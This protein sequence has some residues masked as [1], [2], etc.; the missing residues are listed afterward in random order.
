M[1]DVD[2]IGFYLSNGAATTGACASCATKTM[3]V[4]NNRP[5]IQNICI[6]LCYVFRAAIHF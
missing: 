1:V 4:D 2:L 6:K 3:L 5:V